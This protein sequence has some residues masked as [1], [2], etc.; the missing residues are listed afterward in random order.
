MSMTKR[1]KPNKEE[2]RNRWILGEAQK[3]ARDKVAE[4]LRKH[5]MNLDLLSE[6]EFTAAM[7]AITLAMMSMYS[8]GM[9]DTLDVLDGRD[10][11]PVK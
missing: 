2:R 9:L 5:P 10:L 4:Y 7:G 11:Q 8:Q 6:A 3:C 1:T